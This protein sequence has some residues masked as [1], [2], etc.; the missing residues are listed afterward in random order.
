MH[1]ISIP[2]TATTPAVEFDFSAGR[3]SLSGESWPENAAAFYRPLL[4][5]VEG[6]AEQP[7]PQPML[8]IHVALSYFN[9]SSTKM[10]FGLFALLNGVAEGGQPTELHWYFDAEDDVAEEFGQE[11]SV[12]FPA[13]GVIFHPGETG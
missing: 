2:A 8:S 3:L 1:T 11:L 12:D 9:S 6:W 13:I 10:L 7:Q 5:A 4:A